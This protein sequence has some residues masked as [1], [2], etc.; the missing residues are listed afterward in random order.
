MSESKICKLFGVLCLLMWL[1]CA[2]QSEPVPGQITV[3]GQ[4]ADAETG[5]P[6]E[7]VI[8]YA[9]KEHR[10]VLTDESGHYRL[11]SLLAYDSPLS[12]L[13]YGYSYNE[14]V[15]IY[16]Q[17]R[18]DKGSGKPGVRDFAMKAVEPGP[19][20][21]DS[22]YIE[23]YGLGRKLAEAELQNNTPYWYIGGL[24]AAQRNTIS[25]LTGVPYFPSHGCLYD[26]QDEGLSVGHNDRV[27][28]YI[29]EYG[30]PEVP[31]LWKYRVF[32]EVAQI[33]QDRLFANELQKLW[34]A[35]PPVVSPDSQ[36][37]LRIIGL[38]GNW[39]PNYLEI[40]KV[41]TVLFSKM[42]PCSWDTLEVAWGPDEEDVVV[43]RTDRAAMS[44]VD[45]Q[46]GEVHQFARN[47]RN[48]S[49]PKEPNK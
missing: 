16:G 26:S 18:D 24:G 35:G 12:L 7:N 29:S 39:T 15:R 28:Q 11:D 37:S 27:L 43:L 46:T 23:G 21:S 8:V 47:Q 9:E 40:A 30:I 45:F 42:P 22:G 2:R 34:G 13:R 1:S 5:E 17:P 14:P 41:D 20:S 36:V 19:V 10:R 48:L 49:L 3:E 44:L 38:M 6:L 4:I 32:H 25:K 31:R 33:H